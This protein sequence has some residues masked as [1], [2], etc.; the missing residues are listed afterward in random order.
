M[1]K[2]FDRVK[3]TT[4]VVGTGSATLLG[5]AAGFRAFGSVLTDG[6]TCY[7]VI[8]AQVLGQWEVGIGT[9]AGSGLTLQRTTVLSSS[10]AGALVSFNAG[11]KDVFIDLPAA[12]S[13]QTTVLDMVAGQFATIGS[14]PV[15]L[16]PAQGVGT[17]VLPISGV[18]QYKAGTVGFSNS[19][20]V[21]TLAFATVPTEAV[22]TFVTGS[23]ADLVSMVVF[24]QLGEVVQP[25]IQSD[26]ENVA[27]VLTSEDGDDP[28]LELGSDGVVRVVVRWTLGRLL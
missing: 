12:G 9:I 2:I 7:Y 26:C 6:D 18:L 20:P 28:G 5:A 1:P 4:S 24:P 13:V 11:V 23:W 21:P 3:E 19:N 22:L 8:A 25:K 10:N 27:L 16:V 17:V 14:V 15:N